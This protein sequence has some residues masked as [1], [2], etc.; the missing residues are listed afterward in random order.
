VSPEDL[1]EATV[2]WIESIHESIAWIAEPIGPIDLPIASIVDAI[3]RV[4]EPTE[5]TAEPIGSTESSVAS[6]EKAIGSIDSPIGSI[7]KALGTI[8]RSS[9][10]R[11][12]SLETIRSTIHGIWG[13]LA[14]LFYAIR[15]V[16]KA[17]HRDR[18]PVGPHRSS[19]EKKTTS[20]QK[21][22]PAVEPFFPM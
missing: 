12:S 21:N 19:R 4:E 8:E 6:I 3:G 11:K 13:L 20:S 16:R 14:P 1:D 22:H 17:R 7:E 2:L 5:P 15:S 18:S 10:A 9:G